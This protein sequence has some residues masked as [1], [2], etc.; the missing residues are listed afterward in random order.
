MRLPFC[1]VSGG[2]TTTVAPASTPDITCT[3]AS[4]IFSPTLTG[5]IATL[6]AQGFKAFDAASAGAWL[7]ARAG[8]RAALGGMAGMLASDL[9]A[10]L[11]A[12]IDECTP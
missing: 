3:S 2:D 9:I 7:H 8:D 12:T 5:V 11:R 4:P 1:N 10:E 6:L